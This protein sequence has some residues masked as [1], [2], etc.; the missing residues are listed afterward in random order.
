MV[1]IPTIMEGTITIM[2]D[3]QIATEATQIMEAIQVMAMEDTQ[4]IIMVGTQIIHGGYPNNNG[5][6]PGSGNGGYPSNSNGGQGFGYGQKCLSS[7]A[8]T[9]PFEPIVKCD[10]SVCKV[11][12]WVVILCITIFF[13]AA[14]WVVIA[15][16]AVVE[17]IVKCCCLGFRHGVNPRCNKYEKVPV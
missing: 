6:Y 10:D 12:M 17:A 8:D 2:A 5:G 3:T 1:G 13:L 11:P 15:I 4:T 14:T 9:C 16:M 7:P